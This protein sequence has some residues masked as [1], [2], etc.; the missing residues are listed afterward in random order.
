MREVETAIATNDLNVK[1]HLVILTHDRMF[2]NQNYTDSLAKFITL[3]KEHSNYVFETV[4]H[5]PGL[6][7]L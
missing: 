6:K 2:R 5:Y 3:L 4:D 7:K 1:N